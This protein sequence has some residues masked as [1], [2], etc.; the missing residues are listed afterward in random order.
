LSSPFFLSISGETGK[1]ERPAN[2]LVGLSRRSEIMHTVLNAIELFAFGVV[3][4][5]V[6][7][8]VCFSIGRFAK[9]AYR[10][11]IQSLLS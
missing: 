11:T 2:R 8:G 3:G 1:K 10:S 5:A 9:W 6:L 7:G 4:G